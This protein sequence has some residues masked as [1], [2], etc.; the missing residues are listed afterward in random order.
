MRNLEALIDDLLNLTAFEWNSKLAEE[1]GFDYEAMVSTCNDYRY[2]VLSED[3]FHAV[4]EHSNEVVK[5][6]L[7]RNTAVAN[8]QSEKEDSE[9]VESEN[10]HELEIISDENLIY[11]NIS[12]YRRA[13]SGVYFNPGQEYRG[14]LFFGLDFSACEMIGAIF[15]E[16]I[17]NNCTLNDV[18]FTD[19][20]FIGCKFIECEITKC[21]MSDTI[22][23]KTSTYG[24]T[25]NSSCIEKSNI[26][27][28]IS[29]MTG[30]IACEMDGSS[31]TACHFHQVD[32]D[33]SSLKN[34]KAVYNVMTSS[35]MINSNLRGIN[36]VSNKLIGCELSRLHVD[37]A[38][39]YANSFTAS[40]VS[41]EL[42]EFFATGEYVDDEFSEAGEIETGDDNE[43]LRERS[44]DEIMGGDDE[45]EDMA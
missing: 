18:G 35:K 41:S 25:F 16:C 6:V 32:F 19:A 31:M 21:E 5:E 12:T 23:T 34:A 9:D 39:Q 1:F 26:F 24:V 3:H 29:H 2:A 36:F 27:E 38:I 13:I 17:F 11:K 14:Y 20:V 37:N 45:D 28:M 42:I 43:E 10:T 44:F 30:F 4:V 33:S 40:S 8:K 15:E 7:D 22:W